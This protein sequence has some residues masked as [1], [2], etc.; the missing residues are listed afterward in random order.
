MTTTLVTGATGALGSVLV[1]TLVARGQRVIAAVRPGHEGAPSAPGVVVKAIELLSPDSWQRALDELERDGLVPDGAVLAAGNWQGGKPLYQSADDRVWRAMLKN[2]LE[3]AHAA[4]AAL[5]PGMV[6]RRRGSVVLVGSRAA[7]RP[8]ES[9]GAAAYAVAKAGVF[10]LTQVTAQE[11]LEHGVRVNAVLPS[12]IDTPSNRAAM[13]KA[14]FSRWVAPEALAEVIA[15][16][17]SDAARAVSGAA[18]PVYG[19]VGV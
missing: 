6:K 2:N 18:L 4:L 16:L 15:F 5:L 8:W 1:Q 14:D 19:Q 12:I 11:V 9:P 13:P 7:E 10:A 3:T 17:L